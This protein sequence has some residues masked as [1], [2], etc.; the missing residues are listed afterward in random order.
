MAALGNARAAVD[1]LIELAGGKRPRGDTRLLRDTPMVQSQVGQAEAQQYVFV[2]G[3]Q[4]NGHRS[5]SHERVAVER[6]RSL[7]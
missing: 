5:S 6:D 7:T 4:P 1:A 3:H 2:D